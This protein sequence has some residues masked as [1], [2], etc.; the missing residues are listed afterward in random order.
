MYSTHIHID[1]HE[2]V[3]SL[4]DKGQLSFYFRELIHDEFAGWFWRGGDD[5][6]SY[7]YVPTIEDNVLPQGVSAVKVLRRLI[8]EMAKLINRSK[9]D[10]FY[11]KP[12]TDRKGDFY[13]NIF[14][15]HL[16]LLNGN[17]NYQ[18]IDKEWFYFN[19][20]MKVISRKRQVTA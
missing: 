12:S 15:S 9:V 7:Y 11:F 20:L 4:G 1:G 19:R 8:I 3:I 10:F 2:W 17:W 18:V 13:V 6:P 5:N 16:H 14:K